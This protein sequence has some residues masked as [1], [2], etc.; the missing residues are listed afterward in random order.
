MQIFGK[1]PQISGLRSIVKFC[2]DHR[3]ADSQL[4]GDFS[5]EK[6]L[7]K[8]LLFVLIQIFSIVSIFH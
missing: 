5:T 4:L 1:L 7:R 3:K 2:P 6:I 8:L